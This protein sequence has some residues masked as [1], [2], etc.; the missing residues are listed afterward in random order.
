MVELPLG[1]YCSIYPVGIV[2]LM[3]C[4]Q[5]LKLEDDVTSM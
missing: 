2:G 1:R 3:K 4:C 5:E